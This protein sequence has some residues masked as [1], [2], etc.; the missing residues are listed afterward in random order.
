MSDLT[1]SLHVTRSELGLGNLD[2]NDQT[3]YRAAG[4]ELNPGAVQWRR[5]VVNSPF[6]HGGVV[7]DAVRDTTQGTLSLYAYGTTIPQLKSNVDTAVEAFSQDEY[8]VVFTHEGATWTWLCTQADYETGF[9]TFHLGARMTPIR[10][11]FFRWSPGPGSSD[12]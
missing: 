12:E 6:V 11:S 7:M 4:N 3:N 2:L 5:E 10:F 1:I 8:K 9:T